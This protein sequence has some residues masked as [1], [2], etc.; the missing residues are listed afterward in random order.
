M[1]DELPAPLTDTSTEALRK[2]IEA[3][4]VATRLYNTDIPVEAH[5]EPDASWAVAP[6]GDIL[7]SVVVRTYIGDADA[8]SRIDEIIA[9]YDTRGGGIVWWVAP[10]HTPRD[11]GARL[12]R[13]G[14]THYGPSA[15]MALDLAN[16]PPDG[17]PSIEGVTI[18]PVRDAATAAD[19][20]AVIHE[21]RPE[22]VPPYLA[23]HVQMTIETVAS[24]V[25]RQP[26]PTY[27]VGRLEGRAVATS[28]LSLVGGTAGI[29]AVVTL[30]E[31]RGRGIGSLMTLAALHAARDRGY[32][33]ATLQSSQMG[34][35][36][37]RRLGFVD[38]FR[39]GIHVPRP[40]RMAGPGTGSSA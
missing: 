22:G 12:D 19:Y 25:A 10:F 17:P 5:D 27:F 34:R 40:A 36:L 29:Y 38:V 30:A 24:R 13:R 37:Y 31:A 33:V 28:R 35:D 8:D 3:D 2:A 15:A 1:T 16:L 32:R 20:V 4:N 11:L 26:F 18:E 21:D 39:Y 6:R 9:T 23:E 7:R 14:F